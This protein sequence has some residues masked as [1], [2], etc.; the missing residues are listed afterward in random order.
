MS[1]L[2]PKTFVTSIRTDLRDIASIASYMYRRNEFLETPSRIASRAVESIAEM[3]QRECPIATQA[4][5]LLT[6]RQLGYKD[7]MNNKSRHFKALTKEIEREK[8]MGQK[9]KENCT[10]VQD[11]MKSGK[12]KGT[13]KK[14]SQTKIKNYQEAGIL[15]KETKSSTKDDFETS[16]RQRHEEEIRSMRNAFATKTPE[17]AT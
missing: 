2:K 5:A 12:F 8:N 7:P 3:T 17:I 13:V 10:I 16:D 6:L 11:L 4:E 9:L 14:P 1:K 15:A